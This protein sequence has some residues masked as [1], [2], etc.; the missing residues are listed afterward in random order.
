MQLKEIVLFAVAAINFSL[1]LLI[2]VRSRRSAIYKIFSLSLFLAACWNL[3]VFFLERYP[4]LFTANLTTMVGFLMGVSLLSFILEFPNPCLKKHKIYYLISVICVLL[5]LTG[6][7]FRLLIEDIKTITTPTFGPGYFLMMLYGISASS[8]VVINSI[9]KFK[10][11]KGTSRMQMKYLFSGFFAFFA[12]MLTNNLILPNFGIL[13]F[14]SLGPAFSLIFVGF[15]ACAIVKH[16]LMDIRLVVLKSAAYSVILAVVAGAYIA[17]TYL[18]LHK[19]PGIIGSDELIILALIGAVFGVF[20]LRRL[21][22]RITDKIFAKGRY[23]PQE[24][25]EKLGEIISTEVKLEDLEEAFLKTLVKEMRLKGAAFGLFSGLKICNVKDIGLKG[26]SKSIL[27]Q[28]AKVVGEKKQVVLSDDL[29]EGSKEKDVLRK[30]KAEVIVPLYTGKELIGILSL[31]EKKSG[32]MFTLEDLKVFESIAPQIATGVKKTIV[33]KERD[34]AKEK[35]MAELNSLNSI[36][37]SLSSTLNLDQVLA[38]VIEEA[39]RVTEAE[40][41]SIM[42]LDE[43]TKTLS[44]AASKGINPEVTKDTKV[45]LGEGVSGWAAQKGEPLLLVDGKNDDLYLESFLNREDVTSSLAVPLMVK[46][47]VIGVL[48]A[49]RKKKEEVFTQEDLTLIS[50]FAAHAAEH[51]ENARFHKKSE[52]QFMETINSLSKAV[53]AKDHYTHGHSEAVTTHAVEIAEEMGLPEDEIRNIKIAA[54]LHDIG[55]IGIPGDILNKPAQLTHEERE[56]ICE[57]PKIAVKILQEAESLGAIKPLIHFH[58]ERFDGKGYPAGLSG[59][60]IPLGARIL[61]VADSFNAMVTRRPYRPALSFEEACRELQENAETQFDPKV[62][63][64]F[65]R[66]LKGSLPKQSPVGP[67]GVRT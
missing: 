27:K 62:V 34:E 31:G 32:D 35:R 20:P 53:D 19:Y 54:R 39:L 17:A 6:S 51:L 24:L 23:N 28:A 65:L 47:K 61:A 16:R 59:T 64:A 33:V 8:Y 56:I 67:V 2:Y 26:V 37:L 42:L 3:N 30:I 41:G 13:Y 36:V 49:S 52:D 10:K 22:E 7:F 38:K 40:C 63:E 66:I 9:R 46:G 25:L 5:A 12:L 18:F 60:E 58:H 15:T 48:N 21:F 44:I 43:E 14:V 55:K 29:E 50:S 45:R 4:N 11:S 57:H 1:A